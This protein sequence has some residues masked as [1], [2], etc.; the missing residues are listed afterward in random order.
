M[1][2]R[3][4]VPSPAPPVLSFAP[5]EPFGTRYTVVEEVGAGGMGQ[6]YKAI[7]RTLGRTV[8]LKLIRPGAS[9]RS[10]LLLRFRRELALAQAVTHPNVCRVHDLGEVRGAVYISMEFIE[11]QS[12]EDLI[13]SVGH[14]SARQTIAFGRQV[15]AGLTAIHERSIVHRDLKPSNVMV[16]RAGQARVMDFGMAYHPQSEKLTAEGSVLGTLAYVA[17]EAA[18]GAPPDTRSDIYAVGVVLFEMLTGRRPPGDDG[19]LPLA[20]REPAEPCPPPSRVSPEVP[21]ALDAIVLRCLERD[22]ER[23]FASAREL[24]QA[25]ARAADTL[26]SSHSAPLLP[27]PRLSVKAPWILPGLGLAAALGLAIL[28]ARAFWPAPPASVALLSLAYEGPEQSEAL[29]DLLPLLLTEQLRTVTGL[30]VAPFSNARTFGPREDAQSV[31]RQLGVGWV[32]GGDVRVLGE[33]LQGGLRLS[34]ADGREVWTKAIQGDL[35]NPFPDAAAIAGE[36]ASVLGQR[37]PEIRRGPDPRALLRYVEGTRFLEGWDVER[38]YHRAAQAFREAISLDTTF[39]EAHAGMAL[40]LWKE[41]EETGAA[42]RVDE[43][44]AAADRALSLAASLPEAQLAKGVVQLGR[45]QS[46]EAASSFEQALRL[47]PA[48]DGACRRI[49]GAYASL[50]RKEDAERFFDRAIALRPNYWENYNYKGAFLLR[51]GRADAARE[52]FQKVVELRPDSYAGYSNLGTSYIVS[53]QPERAEPFLLSALRVRPGPQAQ[54]ALGIV[55]YATGRFADAAEDFRAATEGS[56]DMTYFGNLGD[57]LRHLGEAGN[58][59]RAYSRAIALG[60]AKLSI[61]PSDVEVRAALSMFLAGAG[62]CREAAAEAAHASGR[63]T[64]PTLHYYAAVAYV[65]CG[66]RRKAVAETQQALEGGAMMD[67]KTNPDLRPLLDEPS[68]QKLLKP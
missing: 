52:L 60:R 36:L 55:H 47:A 17:P 24:E 30:Q 26:S 54:N 42:D 32:V 25:L 34:S 13:R 43:A 20:L 8:A 19:S 35:A 11:G 51:G 15:C 16:D 53:G 68:L 66:E 50:G 1:E 21:A 45:G 46:A 41:F 28:L 5:G 40:A 48:D 6:V 14:L 23:R 59:N 3:G 62:R 27:V 33:R 67:V 58:A 49:A 10:E 61:N 63:T 4:L 64:E 7:D 22:P 38:N 39:A 37:A 44:T 65:V 57:A 12:L 31:A 29:R 9:E 2:P 18:R 56:E